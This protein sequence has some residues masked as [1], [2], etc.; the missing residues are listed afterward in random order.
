MANFILLY[1]GGS[2]PEGQA[3]QAVAMQAWGHG[4]VDLAAPS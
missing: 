3:E 2:M 4:T 1:S